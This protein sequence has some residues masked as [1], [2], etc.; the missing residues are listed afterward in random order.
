[1]ELK[2]GLLLE[3]IE[4]RYMN[5]ELCLQEEGVGGPKLSTIF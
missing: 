3:P 1:M 2:L 5:F 4:I